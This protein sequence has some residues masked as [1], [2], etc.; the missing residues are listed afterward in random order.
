MV[1]RSANSLV[2][3]VDMGDVEI[4]DK[5]TGEYAFKDQCRPSSPDI[6]MA[7]DVELAS[8]AEAAELRRVYR[9]LLPESSV[10]LSRVVCDGSHCG[11]TLTISEIAQL[12][13][14]VE[15]LRHR[16][17]GPSRDFLLK[18]HDLIKIANHE[19]NPI[20]FV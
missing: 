1:F 2:E 14:E 4:L 9:R 7:Y 3:F 12:T 8:I 15:D 5:V 20:V 17:C 18:L 11:D 16:T 13:D 10:L 19:G 6:F